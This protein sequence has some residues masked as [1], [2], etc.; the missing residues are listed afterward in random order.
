MFRKQGGARTYLAGVNQFS[1]WKS[2]NYVLGSIFVGKKQCFKPKPTNRS[3]ARKSSK[4][5]DTS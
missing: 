5:I 4:T 2:L 1:N 3:I